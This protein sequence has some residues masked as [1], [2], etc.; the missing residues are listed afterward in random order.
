MADIWSRKEMRYQKQVEALI[1]DVSRHTDE[2]VMEAEREQIVSEELEAEKMNEWRENFLENN[3]TVFG[4]GFVERTA[5][6]MEHEPVISRSDDKDEQAMYDKVTDKYKKSRKKVDK[7]N[8]KRRQQ[9]V[10]EQQSR[11]KEQEKEWERRI[12]NGEE[13][14]RKDFYVP[15]LA[16]NL[17]AAD[18]YEILKEAGNALYQAKLKKGADSP[19]SRT[20]EVIYQ[21]LYAASEVE[22]S[23]MNELRAYAELLDDKDIKKDLS[24]QTEVHRR[25]EVLQQQRRL[26]ENRRR[27]LIGAMRVMAKV[28]DGA[29]PA[30]GELSDRQKETLRQFYEVSSV[31][32]QDRVAAQMAGAARELET[33]AEETL[34]QLVTAK[35]RESGEL[36]ADEALDEKTWE[37]LLSENRHYVMAQELD[38]T[39]REGLATQLAHALQGTQSREDQAVKQEVIRTYADMLLHFDAEPYVRLFE[40]GDFGGLM[41]AMKDLAKFEFIEA[42]V[43]FFDRFIGRVGVREQKWDLEELDGIGM[44]EQFLI[45][46]KGKILKELS[47]MAR[48]LW[49]QEADNRGVSVPTPRFDTMGWRMTKNYR[50]DQ[51]MSEISNVLSRYKNA[52]EADR[53]R[54]RLKAAEEQADAAQTGMETE[55]ET[56]AETSI[57]TNTETN[58]ETDRDITANAGTVLTRA[59]AINSHSDRLGAQSRERLAALNRA[60]QESGA[61]DVAET[62]GAYVEGTRYAVGYTKERQLLKKAVDAVNR[63]LAADGENEAL[64]AVRRYFDEMTNGTLQVPEAG[65]AEGAAPVVHFDYRDQVPQESGAASGG[66]RTRILRTFTHWS[67]QRD[68]PL[69][70]HEPTVN[71][72]KQRFV[73]NCYMVAGVAGVVDLD[74]A[75]IKSCIRDNL[76]GTVTVRLYE[77]QEVQEAREEPLLTGDPEIDELL[78]DAFEVHRVLAPVYVTVSKDI[79]RIGGADVLSAGALWMQMIEKACAF[80]GRNGATGY[81]SLWYGEGGKFLTRLFGVEPTPVTEHDGLFEDI[82]SARERRVVYNAG[83]PDA[84]GESDGLNAGHAYTVMGAKEENGTRYVLLRNPYSTMSLREEEGKISRTGGM[85]DRSSDETYGQFYM[86]YEDFL[87]KFDRITCTAFRQGQQ[88]N[89]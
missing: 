31:T 29:A 37:R 30:E 35:L 26:A 78:D 32:A 74:P 22:A 6:V 81:G 16:K 68:T 76:D 80:R 5:R 18:Q 56:N 85:F 12:T 59:D 38:D 58:T 8:K 13:I 72:L 43:E 79:P 88:E 41:R 66:T 53:E 51:S 61:A 20:L 50:M 42:H 9:I 4:D 33:E 73:S 39:L 24:M 86:K 54:Q 65:Q 62:V 11:Q 57:A 40:Q 82:L 2:K 77:Y 21:K 47:A 70:S 28:A 34:R 23:F 49:E 14:G 7:E 19:E 10:K 63:G 15:V 60:L 83:T 45:L 46:Y 17:F 48:V 69:F 36:A 44:D 25:I 64:A 3:P 55:L 75:L 52:L 89:L 27:D 84:V 1:K 71:D 87:Q 67:S